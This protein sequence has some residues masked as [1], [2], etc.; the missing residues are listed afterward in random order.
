MAPTSSTSCALDSAGQ[1]SPVSFSYSGTKAT[2][3]TKTVEVRAYRQ[4][5]TETFTMLAAAGAK[6]TISVEDIGA[7]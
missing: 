7:G 1:P 4:A 3:R 5:G 6:A 2:A